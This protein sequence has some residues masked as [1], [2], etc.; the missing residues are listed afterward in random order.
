MLSQTPTYAS[1]APHGTATA[2]SVHA[3]MEAVAGQFLSVAAGRP[4]LA[5][6]DLPSGISG[7]LLGTGLCEARARANLSWRGANDD[8]T[9]LGFGTAFRLGGPRGETFEHARDSFDAVIREA[10]FV[11]TSDATRPR[12]F[13]GGRFQPNGANAD[14][15]WESFEGW[16]LV[17]PRFLL[18]VGH[19]GVNASA[20]VMLTGKETVDSLTAR[21]ETDFAE[22]LKIEPTRIGDAPLEAGLTPDA[23]PAAVATAT[24]EISDGLYAKVVLARQRVMSKGGPI[25]IDTLLERLSQRYPNCFVFRYAT[26]D[27]SWVG[28]S[29][30][31]LVSLS[32]GEAHATSLAA[33]RPRGSNEQEDARLG[34]ELL[35]SDKERQEHRFVVE[36]S[37]AALEPL[38]RTLCFPDEPTLL[39]LPNIQHLYTPITCEVK[40]GINILDLVAQMHP[41]PAVGTWPR[42]ETLATI[43]R[44]EGMDRGWYAAP[45]GW[46]DLNGDGEFAVALRSALVHGNHA[47]LYA[48]AGIVHGSDPEAELAE[49]EL[50]FRPLT[51]AL[52]DD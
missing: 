31:L 30:E 38:S 13:G 1:P 43:E 52:S 36:A 5:S 29:P 26:D 27:A 37:K 14:P 42:G 19:Q 46:A 15:R 12:F 18:A 17:M 41:T 21:L 11:T 7:S 50:K 24:Q 48:G 22:S 28:A 6:C 47:T 16:Q 39:R 33:S 25:R 51:Y 20:T 34:H 23:Y 4:G 8:L 9:L 32:K 2:L 3:A 44:L 10:S 49:T 45:I 40:S 35:S